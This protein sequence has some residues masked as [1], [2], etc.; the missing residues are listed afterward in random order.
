MNPVIDGLEG[1]AIKVVRGGEMQHKRGS[2]HLL[3]ESTPGD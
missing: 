1:E 3:M 2:F